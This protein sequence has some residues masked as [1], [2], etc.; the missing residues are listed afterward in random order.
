M[1][2]PDETRRYAG[3]LDA[4]RRTATP[5]EPLSERVPELDLAAAYAIQQEFLQLVLADGGRIAGYKIGL[6]SAPM[7]RLLGVN[8]P[9]YSAFPSTMVVD[10]GHDFDTASFCAPRIEAEIGFMLRKPLAG[11]GVNLAQAADAIGGA[12]GSLEVVDSRI[13]DWRIRLTDTIADLASCGAVVLGPLLVGMDGW[14][15]RTLGVTVRRNG[16]I[17]ATGAGAA[18][19]GSPVKALAWLANALGSFGVTLAEGDVVLTGAVHAA[20]PVAAGDTIVADLHRLGSVRC[21]FS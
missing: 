1:L 11:P 4:A 13:A 15:P 10:D 18:V 7:Q 12:V 14:D 9:D 21:R 19:M 5:V 8:E 20:F 6:T 3:E 16:E 2:N 17:E